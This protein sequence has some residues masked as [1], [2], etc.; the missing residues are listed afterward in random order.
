M[1]KRHEDR[2]LEERDHMLAVIPP[3]LSTHARDGEHNGDPHA[4]VRDP[5]TR[6]LTVASRG[7]C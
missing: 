1:R 6:G 7:P 4:G 2:E 5:V 3:K